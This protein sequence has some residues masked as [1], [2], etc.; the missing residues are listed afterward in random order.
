MEA[1]WPTFLQRKAKTRMFNY[2]FVKYP[3]IDCHS[4]WHDSLVVPAYLSGASA[5][6]LLLH[7]VLLSQPAKKLYTFLIPKSQVARE[8]AGPEPNQ[9]IHPASFFGQVR[10]HISIHGGGIIYAYKVIRLVGCLALL[11]LSTAT[12]ILEETGQIDG[13]WYETTGKWGKKHPK[14][15]KKHARFTVDEWLQVALCITTVSPTYNLFG[16]SGMG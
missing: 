9:G 5:V 1:L 14:H 13:F 7:I 11:A 8:P 15:R 10:A 12:L 2:S 4:I 6:L 3:C 16:D